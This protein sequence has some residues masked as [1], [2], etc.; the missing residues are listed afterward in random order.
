V[1]TDPHDEI[2]ISLDSLIEQAKDDANSPTARI[3]AAIAAK[4]FL[5]ALTRRLVNLAREENTSWDDIAVLFGT[6]PVN[7]KARFGDYNDYDD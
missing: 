5:E 4:T 2:V 3:T 7:A 6:S 1:P